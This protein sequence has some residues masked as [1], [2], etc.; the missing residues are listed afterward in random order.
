MMTAI[1]HILAIA[2]ATFRETLRSKVLY[3]VMVFMVI[4]VGVSSLFGAVTIGDQVKVIKDFGL[5]G[6]S[7]CSVLFTILSG[8]SL[9]HKEIHRKTIYNI[10]SKPVYRYEFLVGKLLGLCA[11]SA[12]LIMCMGVLLAGYLSFFSGA[13]DLSILLD[14]AYLTIECC[15]E[16]AVFWH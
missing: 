1:E 8:V 15:I 2:I 13:L 14:V 6:I 7:L 5:A 12:I 16:R 3:L 11:T 9:L 10:L 4:I